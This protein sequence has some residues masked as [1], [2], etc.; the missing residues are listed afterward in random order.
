MILLAVDQAAT[1][2]FAIGLLAGVQAR[3]ITV[4][5]AR[6]AA[7]RGKAIETAIALTRVQNET[8]ADIHVIFE[9]HGDFY[10]GKGNGSVPSLLGLGAARGRWLEQLEL[11]GV[12]K[13]KVCKVATKDWRRAVLGLAG[14]ASAERAKSAAVT[15]AR[16]VIGQDVEHDAAEALCILLW[17]A[18]NLPASIETDKAR[19][20]IARKAKKAG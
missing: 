6:S 3:A 4:G 18:R 11:A 17:A 14:N 8:L 15:H 1:S 20:S 13:G 10:F 16:A 12:K 9:D 5:T 2:G 19:A 7:E